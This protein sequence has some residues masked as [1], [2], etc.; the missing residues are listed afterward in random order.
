MIPVSNATKQAW[1]SETSEKKMSILIVGEG[2]IHADSV[3]ADTFKYTE[4][5]MSSDSFEA[6][7]C[8]AKK[9]EFTTDGYNRPVLK[10]KRIY[11]TIQANNTDEINL[12]AG[13]VDS[14]IK[15]SRKGLK[16]ITAYDEFYR[17]SNVD[18]TDWYNAL[19]VTTILGALQSFA[20]YQHFGLANDLEL[21][22]G[23]K[24]CFGGTIRQVKKLSGLDFLKQI[25]QINGCYGYFNG[26][27]QFSVKYLT[28]KTQRILY[29]SDMLFPSDD[30]YPSDTDT[31]GDVVITAIDAYKEMKYEDYSIKPIDNVIIRN[32]SKDYGARFYG[33]GVNSYIIQGNI[34]AYDQ[35]YYDLHAMVV[36]I[37]N[38]LNRVSFRP[39][40]AEQNAYP[41]LECGDCISYY[42]IDD[43]GEQITIDTVIMN[44]ELSGA[45]LMWD[46]YSADCEE[47]Q[48]NTFDLKA[49]LK[50]IQNQIE[51]QADDNG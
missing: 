38:A 46:K 2:V 30:I 44:R 34:F 27:G 36:K 37:F 21:I 5:I 9:F 24:P 28:V 33:G 39:F 23:D 4:S 48:L 14:G 35:D 16:K 51:E 13:L 47:I 15:E 19:G 50:D 3:K 31:G 41:W 12:F 1:A 40:Q 17:L 18:V 6:V 29:P 26:I 22:N 49:Q 42:D 7:G 45:Q 8:I 25:C 10:N 11:A 20:L 32:T 43:N